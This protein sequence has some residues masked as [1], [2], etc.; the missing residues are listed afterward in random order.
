MFK[1]CSWNI[2]K[3]RQANFQ[4]RQTNFQY[5]LHGKLPKYQEV[6]FAKLYHNII[7]AIS[8]DI[9][10]KKGVQVLWTICLKMIQSNTSCGHLPKELA[11]VLFNGN[12]S[13]EMQDMH[14][15]IISSI[16]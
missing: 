16:H 2:S 4:Y 5:L 9:C 6:K 3:L 12:L 8:R 10:Q 14:Q 1:K 15:N 13:E 11:Q 7:A